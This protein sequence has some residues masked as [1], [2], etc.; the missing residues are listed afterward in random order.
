MHPINKRK[1]AAVRQ[2]NV[3]ASSYVVDSSARL[4]GFHYTTCAGGSAPPL[5]PNSVALGCS[6]NFNRGTVVSLRSARIAG[7]LLLQ[8]P[9]LRL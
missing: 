4:S 7:I 5:L 9:L 1:G 6:T 2:A 3:L 8:A